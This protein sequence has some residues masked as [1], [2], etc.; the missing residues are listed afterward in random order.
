MT[1]TRLHR[2]QPVIVRLSPNFPITGEVIASRKNTS[3]ILTSDNRYLTA[4]NSLIT[5]V[6]KPFGALS[7]CGGGK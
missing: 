2:G 6:P 1:D 5:V 3:V 4:P 7:N